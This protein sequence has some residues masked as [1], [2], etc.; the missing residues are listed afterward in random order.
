VELHRW[1]LKAENTAD[2]LAVSL[3]IPKSARQKV[4]AVINSTIEMFLEFIAEVLDLNICSVMLCD[5]LS[6]DLTIKSAKGL[7]TS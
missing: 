7:T 5:E 1:D 4:D 6:G 3:S 2:G